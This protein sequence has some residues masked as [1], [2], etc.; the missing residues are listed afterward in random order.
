MVNDEKVQR[1]MHGSVASKG[2]MVGGVGEDADDDAILAEYDR[3]GGLVKKGR[4]NVK[5]GSFYDF[6][7]K[8]PHKTPKPMLV[9]SVNGEI[10]EVEADK[11]LPI[12]VQAAEI[13]NQKKRDRKTAK[14]SKG[15]DATEENDEDDADTDDEDGELA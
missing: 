13:A 3:L 5:T 6:K 14:A 12:E 8:R 11:P 1:A 9:F 10:V 4:H 2:L 7:N 15:E